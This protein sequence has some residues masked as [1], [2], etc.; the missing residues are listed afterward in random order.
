[1][2]AK[3][4][5]VWDTET[6]LTIAGTYDKA[7]DEAAS[8]ASGQAAQLITDKA[9]I[10]DNV[11]SILDTATILG[12]AGTFSLTSWETP[13]NTDPG[14]S[15]VTSGTTYKIRNVSKSGSLT[16][17]TLSIEDTQ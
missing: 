15:N 13:R 9:T 5:H 11:A 14:E 4:A 6:I 2:T 3:K 16:G 10:T 12:I 7:A 1:V 17:G 8:Y